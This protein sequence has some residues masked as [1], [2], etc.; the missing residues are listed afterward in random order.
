ML[1]TTA[2]AN[3]FLNSRWFTLGG[4]FQAK[5]PPTSA[6]FDPLW[7][8]FKSSATAALKI[9]KIR[10]DIGN[11]N[12]KIMETSSKTSTFIVRYEICGGLR[13]VKLKLV[14]FNHYNFDIILAT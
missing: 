13:L 9:N 3:V 4:F 14:F 7:A 8:S 2:C 6:L 12:A 1:L 5:A 11:D 10:I